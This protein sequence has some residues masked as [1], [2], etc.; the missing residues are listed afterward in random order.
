MSIVRN[1]CVAA[2]LVTGIAAPANAVVFA[3]F[4]TT[5]PNPATTNFRFANST[6][7]LTR[8]TDAVFGTSPSGTTIG[9][10]QVQFSFAQATGL[11]AFVT[12]VAA[13]LI[14]TGTVPKNT[15]ATGALDQGGLGGSFSFLSTAPISV[16][17]GRLE[18]T[19]YAA[20]SNLLTVAFGGA[21]IVGTAG[22]RVGS[23]DG[24]TAQGDMVTFTSD[25]LDFSLAGNRSFATSLTAMTA[26]LSVG[27]GNNKALRTFRARLGTGTFDASVAPTAA[28]EV[29]EPQTWAML[30]AGFA[31]VG[32]AMRRRL[33]RPA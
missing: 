31:L 8:T 1:L 30:V 15:P 28:A 9:A 32:A 29:P 16:S 23:F 21:N 11:S 7:S 14:V 33:V 24:F 19:T 12:N 27:T 2:M 13:S 5:L 18:A 22:T 3:N 20:G 26:N 17:G 6:S 10:V 25:F 4:A